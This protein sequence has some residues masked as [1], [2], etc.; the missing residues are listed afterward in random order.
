MIAFVKKY[1]PPKPKPKRTLTDVEPDQEP[2]HSK[3]TKVNK[4]PDTSEVIDVNNIFKNDRREKGIID[5]HIRDVN[6]DKYSLR[7]SSSSNQPIITG[8]SSEEDNERPWTNMDAIAFA[9]PEKEKAEPDIIQQPHV[10]EFE[11]ES[12][13]K[14]IP[15]I[16][17]QDDSNSSIDDAEVSNHDVKPKSS[18]KKIRRKKTKKPKRSRKKKS[19]ITSKKTVI[20]VR[21]FT[22]SKFKKEQVWL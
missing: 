7:S 3:K 5:K 19:N 22:P 12:D 21:P 20:K 8:E 6:T 17:N 10:V 18:S 14:E 11:M 2:I 15:D 13:I 16:I 1:W 9:A 4:P